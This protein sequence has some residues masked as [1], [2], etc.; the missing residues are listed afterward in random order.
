MISQSPAAPDIYSLFADAIHEVAGKSLSD[1]RA[2]QTI[3]EV[4]LD[5]IAVMEMVGTVE[6]CLSLRFSDDDLM[7]ISTFGDLAALIEKSRAQTLNA[8]TL[9]QTA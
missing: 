2:N 3:A 1:V 4:G 9:Q 7:R 5:S 8:P 6:E